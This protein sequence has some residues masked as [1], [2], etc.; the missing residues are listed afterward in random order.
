MSLGTA[1][2]S[3]IPYTGEGLGLTEL[4]GDLNIYG[5]LGIGPL[6]EKGLTQVIDYIKFS[7]INIDTSGKVLYDKVLTAGG[8]NNNPTVNGLYG[9]TMSHDTVNVLD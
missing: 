6:I 7:R 8:S 3:E 9:L 4:T 2:A 5:S 1:P